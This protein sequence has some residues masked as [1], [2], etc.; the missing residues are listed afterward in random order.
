LKLP[1]AAE[2]ER[3]ISRV[4]AWAEEVFPARTQGYFVGP[5]LGHYIDELMRD[6][7]LETRR[8]H[9]LLSEYFAPI[10]PSR[11]RDVGQERRRARLRASLS[12]F[13]TRIGFE[14]VSRR[15]WRRFVPQDASGQDDLGGYPD[16]KGRE[17]LAQDY[18]VAL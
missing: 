13:E 3:E 1:A 6:M 15:V 17:L 2:M 4:H 9:H 12:E 16:S 8:T 5:F 10:W 14:D 11:S 18:D 7:G